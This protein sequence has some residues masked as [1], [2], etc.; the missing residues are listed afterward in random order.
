MLKFIFTKF[1]VNH[2][3][4]LLSD[5]LFGDIFQGEILSYIIYG[6]IILIHTFLYKFLYKMIKVCVVNKK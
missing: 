3:N 1:K 5:S 2:Q 4:T 6:T